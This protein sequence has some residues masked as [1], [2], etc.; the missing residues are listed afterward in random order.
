MDFSEVEESVRVLG[1]IDLKPLEEAFG[2]IQTD[3]IIITNERVEHIF[4]RH[5]EDYALFLQYG[6]LT[7]M[8]PDVVIKDH[9]NVGT[10]FMVK[11]ISNMN[12]NAGVRV[13][14]STDKKGLKNSVMT[15]YRLRDKNLGKIMERNEVLYSNE[16]CISSIEY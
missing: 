16:L 1:K 4:E 7:V 5:R 14:L 8:Q 2:E 3:E 12:V 11:K 9:K 13:A 15:F 6:V 10:V